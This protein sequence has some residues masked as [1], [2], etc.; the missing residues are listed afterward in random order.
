MQ[1]PAKR[2]FKSVQI[3]SRVYRRNFSRLIRARRLYRQRKRIPMRGEKALLADLGHGA[4]S[5]RYLIPV[6]W[7]FHHGGYDVYLRNW[8]RFLKTVHEEEDVHVFRS[9][10]LRIPCGR[11]RHR[12]ILR[13][14][15]AD[16]RSSA[17]QGNATTS[18]HLVETDDKGNAPEGAVRLPFP[19]HPAVY[20]EDGAPLHAVESNPP[21][22]DIAVGFAGNMN[23]DDYDH[24]IL[25][26][27]FG[28]MTRHEIRRELCAKLSQ[29]ILP[30][31][32]H[33]QLNELERA[34][35]R[36]VLVNSFRAGLQKRDYFHFLSRSRFFLAMPGINSPFA[37]NLTEAMAAGAVPIL[38]FPDLISPRLQDG[39]N[40]LVFRNAQELAATVRK[41]RTMPE[42]EVARMR[43][44]VQDLYAQ[45]NTGR[46]ALS[47]IE[48]TRTGNV[49][50][51]VVQA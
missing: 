47:A 38:Q 5:S 4:I 25:H 20:I 51:A 44:A 21:K 37:H 8:H 1:T 28:V 10:W 13:L 35:N 2:I 18:V 31:D 14:S 41:A 23:P 26:T 48:T 17:M 11:L 46:S 32:E 19:M 49:Q 30:I 40:C 6:L 39:K 45:E 29:Q 16:N 7:Y 22:R 9:G 33:G 43:N 24:P 15:D 12:Q 3:R 42:A 27:R 36:L 50:C 34:Q